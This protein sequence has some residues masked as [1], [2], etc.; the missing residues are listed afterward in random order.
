MQTCN[1]VLE[2]CGLDHL[3]FLSIDVEGAEFDVL[4]GI[5]LNRLAPKVILIENTQG[6]IGNSD[7]RIFLEKAGYL[8]HSRI[9]TCDDVFI[10][11]F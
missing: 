10:R 11:T 8:F 7:L 9:W 5:D 1:H 2:Q 4:L 3:D 6:L